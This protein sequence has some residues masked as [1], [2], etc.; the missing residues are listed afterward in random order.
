MVRSDT[1]ARTASEWEKLIGRFERKGQSRKS[2]CLSQG[3]SLS[4]VDLWR[5]KLRGSTAQQSGSCESIFG[6][7]SQVEPVGTASWDVKL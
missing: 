5:R 4:T 2:F 6:E 1:N 3:V 7:V